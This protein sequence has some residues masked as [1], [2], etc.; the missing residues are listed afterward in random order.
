[1]DSTELSHSDLETA[2]SPLLTVSG[3][4]IG[5]MPRSWKTKIPQGAA[6]KRLQQRLGGPTYLITVIQNREFN[7]QFIQCLPDMDLRV[8]VWVSHVPIDLKPTRLHPYGFDSDCLDTGL[9]F[10]AKPGNDVELLLQSTG[11]KVNF[12]HD[13]LLL[14]VWQASMKDKLVGREL[15]DE[16]WTSWKVVSLLGGLLSATGLVA[17]RVVSKTA[18]AKTRKI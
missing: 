11:D 14:P 9:S 2:L 10:E 16:F 5:S 3:E 6:W 18:K 1:M 8:Q 17:L 7:H 12:S 13:L 15:A 4:Q